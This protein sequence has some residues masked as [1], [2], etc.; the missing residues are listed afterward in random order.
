M[1]G[2]TWT[3]Q[4][5]PPGT[6]GPWVTDRYG[7]KIPKPATGTENFPYNLLHQPAAAGGDEPL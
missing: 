4:T 5:A 2:R 1:T 3:T 7:Q 6:G